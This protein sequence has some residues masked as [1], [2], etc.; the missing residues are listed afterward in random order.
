MEL[1]HLPIID[2]EQS[3]KLA[4]NKNDLA[5]DMLEML[6]NSLEEEWENIKQAYDMNDIPTLHK[7]VHKLHGALCYCGL[8]RL[9]MLASKLE[10]AIKTNI[11]L[12]LPSL[13]D[14]LDNEINLLLEHYARQTF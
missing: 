11:M 4:G 9:K 12:S 1:T 8:P 13:I 3:K 5:R 7:H 6:V 2:W 10:S 14:Q